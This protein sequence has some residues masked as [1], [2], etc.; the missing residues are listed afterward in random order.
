M[1]VY[2]FNDKQSPDFQAELHGGCMIVVL[3]V[4]AGPKIRNSLPTMHC[5]SLTL[6]SGSSND[7]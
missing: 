7:F 4:V 1:N 2:Q 3:F 5:D 6:N